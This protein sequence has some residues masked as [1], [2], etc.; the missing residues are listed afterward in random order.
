[1]GLAP[2]IFDLE[3]RNVTFTPLPHTYIIPHFVI[4]FMETAGD[5]ETPS[6][7]LQATA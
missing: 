5:S 1:M 7:A 4:N 2:T 3:E 6:E